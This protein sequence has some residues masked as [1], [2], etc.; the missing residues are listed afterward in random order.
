MVIPEVWAGT[1]MESCE[2]GEKAIV[3]VVVVEPVW[4]KLELAS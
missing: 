2:Q 4:M 1:E 3:V